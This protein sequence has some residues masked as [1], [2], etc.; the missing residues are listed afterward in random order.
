MILSDAE[1]RKCLHDRELVIQPPGRIGPAGVDLRVDRDITLTPHTQSLVA[2]IEYVEVSKNLAG[3]LHIRSSL[4]REAIIASLALVDPGFRG[5]LTVSLYNAGPK[6]VKLKQGDRFIQL[7]LL[8]LGKPS[9]QGYTGQYQDS[10]GVVTS[11]RRRKSYHHRTE[12]VIHPTLG[13]AGRTVE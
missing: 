5:Q 10:R 3:I 7:S 11:K 9:S 8:R 4:A 12:R 6:L 13:R 1:I 2:S